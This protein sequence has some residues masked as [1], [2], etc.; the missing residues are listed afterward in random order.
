[1]DA[2][3]SRT[4]TGVHVAVVIRAFKKQDVELAHQVYSGRK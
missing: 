1:M 3:S 2:D 4:A